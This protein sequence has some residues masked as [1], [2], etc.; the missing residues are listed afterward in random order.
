MHSIRQRG[1][2]TLIELLVVIAIIAILI[3]LLVPAVQKV[4]EASNIAQCKNNLKQTGLA[5][6]SH[7]DI[8]KVFPS[9]GTWWPDSDARAF[10]GQGR[11][12]AP[13]DYKSQTW[14]WMYQ[15]LPYIE[16]G[17]LWGLPRSQD[18][19]I[20]ATP[21]VTYICPSFR[22]PIVRPYGG[23]VPNR[24]MNDYTANGGSFG[25]W[26]SLT[27]PENSMD[28][29]LVPSQILSK[30][31]RKLSDITDG[32][33]N[34]LLVGEKFVDP[35]N[36]GQNGGDCNDD[37]GY[38][39][40]WDNDAICFA[41]GGGP[42]PFGAVEL[43]KQIDMKHPGTD[44]C[45]LNFGSIHQELMVVFC[46]GSVHAIRFDVDKMVW[47]AVCSMNDGMPTNFND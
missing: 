33:S 30:L 25:G 42:G 17:N 46:D 23:N 21:V 3:A 37:Q 6:Q 16:Q 2:F 29:A 35:A 19:V 4:R 47:A 1:G 15:I 14:G 11:N 9:G 44:D 22:G 20:G 32:T 43:P 12:A 38:L 45:G 13:A 34:T 27:T 8:Y 7:H 28:G 39:D 10:I 24:A 40:G 5:F 31:V 18:A 36:A 41:N 26:W